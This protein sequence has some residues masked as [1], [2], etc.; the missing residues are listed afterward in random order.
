MLSSGRAGSVNM[1]SMLSCNIFTL[2]IT[3]LKMCG[4]IIARERTQHLMCPQNFYMIER[5]L[6]N[7]IRK[8][9]KDFS[10]CG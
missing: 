2:D 8:D 9:G 6:R 1:L 3:R 10:S 4:S 7:P 5:L